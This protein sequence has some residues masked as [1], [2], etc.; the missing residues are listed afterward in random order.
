MSDGTDSAGSTA[1]PEL[2]P[3]TSDRA[4]IE[5]EPVGIGSIALI[6]ISVS[7]AWISYHVIEVPGQRLRALFEVRRATGP[8]ELWRKGELS[9]RRGTDLARL[10]RLHD[11][12]GVAVDLSVL[13]GGRPLVAFLHP[14]EYGPDR[15]PRLAGCLAEARAFRDS[16]FVFKALGIQVVGVT[17]RSPSTI[18]ELRYRERLPFPVLSDHDGRFAAAAG[19]PIW[20]DG[21]GGVFSERITLIVDCRGAIQDTL[22]PHV[23]SI[24]RPSLAA[25]RSEVLMRRADWARCW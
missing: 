18:R 9:V 25:A 1:R 12:D 14:G 4:G 15:H 2:R 11:E 6:I 21:P 24:E 3:A 19:V 23:P 22:G 10:P 17:T 7:A 13:T 5:R 16:A 8:A 20:H